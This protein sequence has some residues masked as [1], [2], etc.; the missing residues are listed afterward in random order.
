[1]REARK[2][3]RKGDGRSPSPHPRHRI[4][5]PGA[6]PGIAEIRCRWK[7][8]RSTTGAAGGALIAAPAALVLSLRKLQVL[9]I[10]SHG[11]GLLRAC[12][13]WAGETLGARKRCRGPLRPQRAPIRSLPSCR[14]LIRIRSRSLGLAPL[15]GGIMR[16]SRFSVRRELATLVTVADGPRV[17][18]CSAHERGAS[19]VHCASA[20]DVRFDVALLSMAYTLSCG[21][22]TLQHCRTR[23]VRMM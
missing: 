9:E 7:G 15:S 5:R 10:R 14:A 3:T 8:R 1:M 19:F 18:S 4:I 21:R 22:A 2:H 13:L 6:G 16:K 12:V 23:R 17:G 11:R 20:Y